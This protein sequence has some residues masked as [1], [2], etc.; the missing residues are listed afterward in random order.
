MMPHITQKYKDNLDAARNA[1]HSLAV[2]IKV[3]YTFTHS[4]FLRL[5]DLHYI[6][7]IT[8]LLEKN[9][10]NGFC[11]RCFCSAASTW[12]TE[13][14]CLSRSTTISTPLCQETQRYSDYTNANNLHRNKSYVSLYVKMQLLKRTLITLVMACVASIM[15]LLFLNADALRV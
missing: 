15:P 3:R 5:I 1:N 2:F 4:T 12:W 8:C 6:L 10:W 7:F 14:L 11:F 13:A 9:W